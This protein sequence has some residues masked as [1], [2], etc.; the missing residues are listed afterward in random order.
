ML[1]TRF[2]ILFILWGGINSIAHTSVHTIATTTKPL[3]TILTAVSSGSKT[4]IHLVVNNM[5]SP[6]HYRLTPSDLRTINKA[7]WLFAIGGGI[8]GFIDSLTDHPHLVQFID[9]QMPAQLFYQ[10]HIDPH[11][12]LDPRNAARMAHI[13][14]EKLA[15]SDKQFAHLYRRNAQ[16]FAQKMQ[17]LDSNITRQLR[18]LR[19]SPLF[20]YHNGFQYFIARYQLNHAGSITDQ[21]TL[22]S[23]RLWN[24]KQNIKKNQH[25][26][27][28]MR[29][30][31]FTSTTLNH[32]ATASTV[33]IGEWDPYGIRSPSPHYA[34]IIQGM[35]D[36]LTV[37]LAITD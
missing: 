11:I 17:R 15:H 27:C 9:H 1:T 7:H 36:A 8:E 10:K 22:T 30:P 29:E 21:G 5:Q 24:I 13:A 19:Q 25:N 26:A 20:T 16:I 31:Q 3:Y 23:R 6:H 35:A 2:V 32:L 18:P 37:C 12:W 14:A 34:D 33:R 4:S 28:I